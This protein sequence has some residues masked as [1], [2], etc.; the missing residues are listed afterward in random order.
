YNDQSSQTNGVI[1]FI[2]PTTNGTTN[3]LWTGKA[4]LEYDIAP[5]V[6]SYATYT[7]GAKPG[8]GSLSGA[9]GS[10]FVSGVFRPEQVDAYEVGVKSRFMNNKIQ[11]NAAAYYYDFRDFQVIGAD[12][13]PFGAGVINIPQSRNFG[14]EVESA[15]LITER[16]RFDFSGS[17]QNSR[18]TS[19]FLAIDGVRAVRQNGISFVNGIGLFD[20]RNIAARTATAQNLQGNRL[21]RTPEFQ[22][23][24]TASYAVDLFSHHD[25]TFVANY[26][27]IDAVVVRPFANPERDFIPAYGLVNLSANFTYKDWSLQLTA[28]NLAGLDAINNRFTDAFGVAATAD[29]LV[30]PRLFRVRVGYRF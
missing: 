1:Y 5:N 11:F 7:R 16:F 14:F 26:N 29:T 4:S 15:W 23:N 22:F 8:A 19:N 2:F 24:A 25:L 6:L 10:A 13:S 12:P 18:I 17:Y 20:P 28:S 30:P 21:P 3:K 9:N 27:W